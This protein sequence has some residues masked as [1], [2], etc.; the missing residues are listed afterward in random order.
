MRAI[1]VVVLFAGAALA[2]PLGFG[3]KAGVPATGLL[4]SS[5]H[6][7][8]AFPARGD[9]YV[10]GPVVELRLP[11]GLGVEA[12]ALYRHVSN[13][14][15]A[16]WEFPILA[17]YRFRGR[18]APFLVGGVSFQRNDV[19]IPFQIGSDSTKGVALGAGIEGKFGPIRL[20]PELRYTHWSGDLAS[21]SY[22][23]KNRSQLEFL[24][25]LTF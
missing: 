25:G 24:V 17:K 13:P 8:G 11:F 22:D 1:L 12:D 15:S 23:L 16:A 5:Y 2:G 18:I 6:D 21:R 14:P 20:S 7:S 4:M 10:I 19:L 3:V 9:H